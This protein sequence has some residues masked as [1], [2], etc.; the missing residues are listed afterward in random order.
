MYPHD[1]RSPAL[2]RSFI[3]FQ[4]IIFVVLQEANYP[5]KMAK[6]EACEKN[7]VLVYLISIIINNTNVIYAV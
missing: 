7:W 2:M 6:T 3:K 4:N 1:P 5:S